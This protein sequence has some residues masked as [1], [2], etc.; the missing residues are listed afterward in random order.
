[1]VVNTFLYFILIKS[2]IGRKFYLNNFKFLLKFMSLIKYSLIKK[3]SI[4]SKKKR[5][6]NEVKFLIGLLSF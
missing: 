1:M 4:R 2:I 5:K 6:N 3:E